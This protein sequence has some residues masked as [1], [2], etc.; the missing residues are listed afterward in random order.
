LPLKGWSILKVFRRPRHRHDA[1]SL[2]CEAP[3]N[4]GSGAGTDARNNGNRF[5]SHRSLATSIVATGFWKASAHQTI[6][7]D[8][9]MLDDYHHSMQQRSATGDKP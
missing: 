7:C 3:D 4:R 6:G 5:V 1:K 2:A 8:G 9:A